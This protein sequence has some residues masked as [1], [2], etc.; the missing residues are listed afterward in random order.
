MRR[1]PTQTLQTL[2][3]ATGNRKISWTP[4]VS[5]VIEHSGNYEGYIY[6]LTGIYSFDDTGIRFFHLFTLSETDDRDFSLTMVNENDHPEDFAMAV[7]L[8]HAIVATQKKKRTTG[9]FSFW[10]RC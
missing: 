5:A 7:S 6:I 3:T 8:Q 4:G 2:Y 9:G 10:K 1:T